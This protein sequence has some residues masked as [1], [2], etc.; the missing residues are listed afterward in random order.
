MQMQMRIQIL[1]RHARALGKNQK[2]DSGATQVCRTKFAAICGIA[3][4]SG[5]LGPNLLHDLNS[6]L[7]SVQV[8]NAKE[9][10]GFLA[11]KIH[12]NCKWNRVA[13]LN[14]VCNSNKILK[15]DLNGMIF[16]IINFAIKFCHRFLF[17]EITKFPPLYCSVQSRVSKNQSSCL[18]NRRE[19]VCQQLPSWKSESFFQTSQELL[20]SVTQ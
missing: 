10:N 4:S 5:E 1:A 17:D 3:A 11:Q 16:R 6:S 9:E 15:Y 12:A 2:Q 18:R 19:N 20:F 7:P 8:W 14:L 13:L